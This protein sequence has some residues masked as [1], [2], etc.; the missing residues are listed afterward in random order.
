MVEKAKIEDRRNGMF[1]S[2]NE[3]SLIEEPPNNS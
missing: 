1:F 3:A 2:W